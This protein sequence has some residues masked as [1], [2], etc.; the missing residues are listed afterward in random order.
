MLALMLSGAAVTIVQRR[1]GGGGGGGG[2]Y[3]RPS[4]HNASPG[5]GV[6]FYGAPV[7][8]AAAAAHPRWNWET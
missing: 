1:K 8:A 2:V 3:G 7:L 5:R 4:R 6:E